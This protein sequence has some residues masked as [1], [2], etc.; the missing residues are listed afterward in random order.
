MSYFNYIA[1]YLK[2]ISVM[3]MKW[4]TF[5]QHWADHEPTLGR[6]LA[7]IGPTLGRWW[8][9]LLPILYQQRPPGQIWHW[10]NIG[11]QYW[12]YIVANMWTDIVVLAAKLQN[13][14][15]QK[16]QSK[17]KISKSKLQQSEF[18][19]EL[20]I[21]SPIEEIPNERFQKES[22]EI[23]LEKLNI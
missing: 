11:C 3:H 6:P 2:S 1:P 7:N 20:E 4:P 16:I 5:G 21:S 14:Q 9:N 10:A 17:R 12:S 19:E 15:I 23:K 22:V 13:R 8:A 18:S